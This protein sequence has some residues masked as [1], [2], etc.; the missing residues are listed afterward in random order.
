M[1]EFASYDAA[2]SAWQ[3]NPLGWWEKAAER[4]SWYRRWDTVFD[5][6]I[7][8][9]G[10]WF[11]GAQLNTCFNCLDR[12]VAAGHGE[13]I[14]LIWDSPMAGS[15]D[16]YSYA[17]LLERTAKLAGAIA[18]L[19][20]SKGDRVLIYMP[21]VPEAVMAMLACARLGAVHCVVFGGFAAQQLSQ[22]IDDARPTLIISASC[23]LEPG[24]I[25]AYKPLLDEAIEM[26]SAPPPVCLILQRSMLAARLTPGRDQDFEA[27]VGAASAHP[28]VPVEATDPLYILYTSGTTA[29]PKG[30]VRDQGGHAVALL[31]SID[32]IYGAKAAD[33]MWTA[34]DV[35]W[36]VGHSYIVYAPLLAR[37]TTVLYEGKPVGTPDAGAFWRVCE[38]HRVNVMF[39][40]PTAL[41]AVKQQD[42]S[43]ELCSRRDL[44]A[45]QA[46]YLA[47]ERCDPATSRWIGGLLHRPIIDHWWQTETG[48]PIT[49]SLR[50]ASHL[51][52]QVGAGGRA[53]PGYEVAALDD[54][55]VAL[56][57]G[58][59]IGNLAVRLPL[60]PGCAPTLWGNDARF[61]KSYLE[62]FPGWYRTGDAGRVDGQGDVWVMG[63]TDDVMNIAGHRFSSAAMEAVLAS[64]PVV[65]E[66]AVVGMAD[67]IKGHVPLG[68]IV[69]RVDATLQPADLT[70]ELLTLMRTHIGPVAAFRH[71]CVVNKLPKTRSG[72]I[73]RAALRALADGEIAEVPPT[74]DDPTVLEEI[75][76]LL[77]SKPR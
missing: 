48:W 7:G 43:G 47:G 32:L 17:Q 34:S 45:L 33:V 9:Y 35:G 36:V 39:T 62:T 8:P 44:S 46:L 16:R 69:R 67:E 27:A 63:R 24:R 41:R 19:G 59:T 51:P 68:F 38:A 14:A 5:P 26:S 61:R 56:P 58:E 4:I 25:I 73:L 74:I 54:Q 71:V 40:A 11:G 52:T 42:P 21:M 13:Q 1:N 12:H 60:P 49:A 66:C 28:P 18:A 65:A 30:V 2:Y 22:R 64:H 53:C 31:Q 55:G 76:V 6:S 77:A 20:V 10:R 50:G 75:R 15:T 37:M 29:L 72:K 70:Q 57:P 3:S 23:G